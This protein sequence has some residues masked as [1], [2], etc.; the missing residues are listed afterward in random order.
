MAGRWTRRG[1]GG[2]AIGL[3]AAPSPVRAQPARPR[4]PFWPG[5]ARLAIGICMMFEADGGQPAAFQP[6]PPGT[7]QASQRFPNLP[8][9]MNRTYGVKEGI[10]RLLDLFDRVGCRVS[11]FMIGESIRRYPDLAREIVARGHEAGGRAIRHAPQFHLPKDEERAFLRE[12][13]DALRTATGLWPKGFNAQGLQGSVNTNDLLQELGL[14]YSIDD[15]TRDEPWI[16]TVNGD[17]DFC[18]VP[19][20][21]HVNDLNFFQNQQ[22]GL[23]DYE[24]MLA[25]EFEV[26]YAEGATRRRMMSVP[27]HDFVAGRPAVVPSVERFLRWAAGHPGVWFA[28]RDEIADWALGRGRELTPRDAAVLPR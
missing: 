26:L 15:R 21:G 1:L 18:L 20:M 22:R 8:M 3:L 9:V 5:G 16:T 27:L 28:R 17:R 14:I 12:G 6:G 11:S 25:Q 2:G 23:A 7:P 10:P 4:G 13:F 19:Y 24:Q